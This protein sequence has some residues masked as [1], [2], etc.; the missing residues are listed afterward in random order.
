VVHIRFQFIDR[1]MINRAYRYLG[2][3]FVCI[4]R[5][6]VFKWKSLQYL[7]EYYLEVRL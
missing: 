4:E 3:Q 6:T 2:L 5:K 1:Y 7:R